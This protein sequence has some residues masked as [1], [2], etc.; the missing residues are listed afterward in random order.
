MKEVHLMNAMP[1]DSLDSAN[2]IVYVASGLSSNNELKKYS[3]DG[4]YLGSLS[5]AK[6]G[7]FMNS[8]TDHRE[9]RNYP[10]DS[11]CNTKGVIRR[12]AL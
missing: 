8:S 10:G 11:S 12:T 1:T 7:A 9:L 2:Q 6:R 3:F 4:K 5:I